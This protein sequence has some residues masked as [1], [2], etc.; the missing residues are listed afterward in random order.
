MKLLQ[1]DESALEFSAWTVAAMLTLCGV[2]LLGAL[3]CAA[4]SKKSLQD[5]GQGNTGK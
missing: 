4:D 1:G 3:P 5:F 2:M